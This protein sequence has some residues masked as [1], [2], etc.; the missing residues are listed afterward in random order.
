MGGSGSRSERLGIPCVYAR[1][2]PRQSIKPSE[3]T[4]RLGSSVSDR[5]DH[6][7]QVHHVHHVEA[8]PYPPP[9]TLAP[10]PESRR[11]ARVFDTSTYLDPDISQE[12]QGTIEPGASVSPVTHPPGAQPHEDPGE[13][14]VQT[15]GR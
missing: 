8:I 12:E 2:R 6:V 3:S 14:E 4:L 15:V 10:P 9:E 11:S 5:G 1:K 7:D 13:S